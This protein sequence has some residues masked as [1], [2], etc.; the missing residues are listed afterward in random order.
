MWR[1]LQQNKPDD[2]VLAT[3]ETHS[4]QEFVN[5]ACKVAGINK[6]NIKSTK[7]LARPY[8]VEH[9][10]GNSKKAAN[11]LGWKPKIKFSKLVKI[12]VEEDIIRWGKWLKGEYF[13]WDAATSEEIIKK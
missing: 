3:G 11:K 13:P 12:M 4:I 9:L 10:Q 6:K 7:S 8:D 2:Y 5:E 1:I